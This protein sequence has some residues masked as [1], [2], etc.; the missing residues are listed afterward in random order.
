MCKIAARAQEVENMAIKEYVDVTSIAEFLT[1]TRSIRRSW[2]QEEKPDRRGGE[3]E[4][5]VCGQN[6][7]AWGLLPKIFRKTFKGGDEKG[8]RLEVQNQ[9][10]PL[11]SGRE[12]SKKRE[13][14]FLM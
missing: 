2:P 7:W 8:I 4:I 12:P 6:S 1:I 11:F 5:W 14:V 10:N 9:T 3:E 13:W